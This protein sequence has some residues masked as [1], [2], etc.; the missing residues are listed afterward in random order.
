MADDLRQPA[1]DRQRVVALASDPSRVDP[2]RCFAD[3]VAIDFPSV[4]SAVD[5]IRVGLLGGEPHAGS[6]H[7]EIRL[8]RREAFDGVT[9]PVA[10]PVRTT[11]RECGGRGGSWMTAC[12]ECAGSGSTL[13]THHVRVSVPA[14]VAHGACVR[15]RVS[16]PDEPP[17]R[18]ELRVA[19]R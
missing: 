12:A 11:C 7:A 19:I 5:R 9:V 3:E 8:S 10:V 15:F 14:R 17:T 16:R 13:F 18:V 2:G 4:G 1:F 6:L